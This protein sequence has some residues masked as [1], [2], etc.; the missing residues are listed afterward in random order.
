MPVVPVV[1]VDPDEALVVEAP[2]DVVPVDEV[3]PVVPVDPVVEVEPVVVV[4]VVA[5]SVNVDL[6]VVV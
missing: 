1:E 6:V 5:N 2:D 3:E 4:A